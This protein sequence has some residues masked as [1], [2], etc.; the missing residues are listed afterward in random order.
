MTL[1]APLPT[2]RLRSANARGAERRAVDSEGTITERSGGALASAPNK[3]FDT[4]LSCSGSPSLPPE[5]PASPRLAPPA[6]ASAAPAPAPT[7]AAAVGADDDEEEEDA[8][9]AASPPP[10]SPPARS[11]SAAASGRICGTTLSVAIF[12]SWASSAPAPS[13]LAGTV[14]SCSHAGFRGAGAGVLGSAMS[15]DVRRSRPEAPA[16]GGRGGRG[17]A[18]EGRAGWKRNGR[19]HLSLQ[20]DGDDGWGA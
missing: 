14:A 18:D 4:Q 2:L 1:P 15:C 16:V 8:A 19:S 3:S 7:A 10:P 6:T 11:S 20:G 9:G 5:G 12:A 17:G 13:G